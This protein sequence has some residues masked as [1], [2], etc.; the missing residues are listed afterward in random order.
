MRA[1][2]IQKEAIELTD[3]CHRSIVEN[4]QHERQMCT[5][6]LGDKRTDGNIHMILFNVSACW[7]EC[8]CGSWPLKNESECLAVEIVQRFHGN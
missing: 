5:T 6:S 3:T 1:W 2:G 4:K 7:Y 8:Q